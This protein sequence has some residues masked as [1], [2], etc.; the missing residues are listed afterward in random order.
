MVSRS[1]LPPEVGVSTEERLRCVTAACVASMAHGGLDEAAIRRRV[2][3]I[4]SDVIRALVDDEYQLETHT[5]IVQ[6]AIDEVL[7]LM[8]RGEW[9]QTDVALDRANPASSDSGVGTI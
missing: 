1:S 6:R 7:S 8:R 4:A 3:E 9:E 2:L 5:A